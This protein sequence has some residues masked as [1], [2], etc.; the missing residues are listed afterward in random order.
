MAVIVMAM[1][2]TTALSVMQRAFLNLDTARNLQVAGS[3]MQTEIEKE[4]LFSWAQLNDATYQP[5]IASSF[6]RNPAVAGRFTLSRTTSVLAAY[7]SQL[8][9]VT[10]SVTWRTHDGRS[11]TRSYTTYFGRGGLYNYIYENV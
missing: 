11:L 4:R 8:I 9:Q 5:V 10:L 7:N 6:M 1:A 2:L 3:I